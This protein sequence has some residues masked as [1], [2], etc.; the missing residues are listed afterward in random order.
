MSEATADLEIVDFPTPVDLP[1]EVLNESAPVPTTTSAP[2]PVE[3]EEPEPEPT[4]A[5]TE[6]PTPEPTVEPSPEPTTEPTPPP[7][8]PS[9]TSN[10]ESEG[11]P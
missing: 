4:V 6:E 1:D 9:P 7:I 5:P 3:T 2:A 10:G 11:D 8:E